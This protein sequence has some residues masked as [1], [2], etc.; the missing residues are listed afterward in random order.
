MGDGARALG[1][2]KGARC[3]AVA[4]IFFALV[5]FATVGAGAFF[6]ALALKSKAGRLETLLSGLKSDQ[7]H[8]EQQQQTMRSTNTDLGS[9]LFAVERALSA[10]QRGAGAEPLTEGKG[11]GKGKGG[12]GK[13]KGDSEGE[14]LAAKANGDESMVTNGEGG[15]DDE[16]EGDDDEPKGKR[17]SKGKRRRRRGKGRQ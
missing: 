12:K 11:K 8:L 1:V 3:C 6:G 4:A 17:G 9:R 7:A 10:Q 14:M 15:K 2:A 16:E 13:G 5:A